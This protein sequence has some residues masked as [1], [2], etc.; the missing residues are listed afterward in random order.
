MKDLVSDVLDGT[1]YVIQGFGLVLLAV[2]LGFTVCGPGFLACYFLWSASPPFAIF[3]GVSLW[4]LALG[5][6]VGLT[7]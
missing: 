7:D 4:L 3:A 1:A 5:A 2:A 6:F